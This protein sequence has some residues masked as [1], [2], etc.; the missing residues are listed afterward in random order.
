MKS[1]SINRERLEEN[2][3]LKLEAEYKEFVNVYV[4]HGKEGDRSYLV[5]N[6]FRLS[7][8]REFAEYTGWLQEIS[9]AVFEKILLQDNSLAFLYEVYM[10]NDLINGPGTAVSE[11]LVSLE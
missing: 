3:I 4:E 9:D 7:L 1:L 8:Y 2:L 5:E 11:I 6:A 10:A